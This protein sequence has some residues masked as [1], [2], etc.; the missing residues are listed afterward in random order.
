V[1]RDR[2]RLARA[3]A[4]L[5]WA[6]FFDWLWLSGSAASFVGPR[7][8]WVVPFGAIVLT[9]AALAYAAGI[10]RSTTASKPSVSQLLGL[11]AL[12]APILAVIIVPKPSLGALAVERKESARAAATARPAPDGDA[13]LDIAQDSA[14]TAF[15]GI[16][17]A[18]EAPELA[19][20]YGVYD[21]ARV[22]L[23]GLV[24]KAPGRPGDG[25]EISRFSTS[26]C[27]ADALPYTVRVRPGPKLRTGVWPTDTWVEVAGPVRRERGGGFV[28][29]AERAT[30]QEEPADPYL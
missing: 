26:C 3:L 14:S 16:A 12:L 30:Q 6:A 5:A 24:S 25:F 10:R 13:G 19:D 27:A 29:V 21:G 18:D 20:S 11:V 1:T 2:L 23:L 15:S 8:I 7:T 22:K 9:G 4:L 28:L 17:I